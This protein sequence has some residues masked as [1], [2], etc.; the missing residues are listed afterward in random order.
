MKERF[1]AWR[2]GVAVALLTGFGATQGVRV[3]AQQQGVETQLFLPTANVGTTFTIDTP[4]VPRHLSFVI[5]AGV[6]G[7][8]GIFTRSDDQEVVPWRADGELLLAFGL[9]EWIELGVAAPLVLASSDPNAQGA[10]LNPT[11]VL[12]AGDIRLS[13]K[14]PILRGDIALSARA[15]FTL[16]TGDESRWLG[17]GYWSLT[18]G[19]VF[20]WRKGPFRLGADLSYRLRQRRGVGAFEQDD[21]LHMALGFSIRV[22]EILDVIA[23][24][25]LRVGVGGRTIDGDE[26]PMEVDAGLRL[27]FGRASLDIGAGT[28]IIAGYGAP[29]I[30]GFAVFRFA[31]AREACAFGPEDF[32]GF[33]DGDFCADPDNDRDAIPDEEDDCAN[34][35][36]DMDGFLDGDGCP[37]DDND[38]DGIA[39]DADR[40]P[41]ESEDRDGYQDTDGCPEPDNDEDGLADGVDACPM[42]PEDRDN[43]EDDDGCPE[44]G[45]GEAVVT[46]DDDRILTNERVYFDFGSATIRSVSFP[47]LELIAGVIMDLGRPIRIEGYTDSEGIDAFNLDLSYRRARAV[48]DFLVEHGVPRRMLDYRGFGEAQPV[49]P[50]DSPEGRALNRRVEFRIVH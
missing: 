46:Y 48:V 24:S 19:L 14:V 25:Q 2:I 26:I 13:A 17:H 30:R 42:E 1:G 9:F 28:G 34:D 11:T 35:A 36:E 47:L 32:D 49:A 3:E 39:D 7:A 5:G 4:E 6:N 21:E 27:N 37:D 31:T 45:P 16:P 10:T 38:A 15:V 23:E 12:R 33:E 40:C 22:H 44:P 8:T 20:A 43:Y 50:N 29:A 41:T 18:P